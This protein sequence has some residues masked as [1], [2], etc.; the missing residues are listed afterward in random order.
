MD[1]ERL[2]YPIGKYERPTIVTEAHRNAWMKDLAAAPGALTS[3]VKDLTDAQ[4]DTPYREGGWTV[5]QVVHHVPDSHMN[6]YIRFK[7]TLTEEMPTIKAYFE[8]RWAKLEDANVAP[9][10]VSLSL[11]DA[12]HKR[13]VLLLKSMKSDDFKR[14]Y[15]H[16]QYGREFSLE[17]VLGLY[18]WHGKHH[19]AHIEALKQR[20]GW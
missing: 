7:W 15:I 4:L 5:R 3:T 14:I 12:L 9:V 16:P 1:I 2:K 17:E 18:A 6:A 10:E 20:M 8:D 11:L 13:W 19:R